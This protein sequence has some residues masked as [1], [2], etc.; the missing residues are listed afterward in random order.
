MQK[1]FPLLLHNYDQQS[2][3]RMFS[4]TD[5][6]ELVEGILV[7]RSMQL[8]FYVMLEQYFV[9]SVTFSQVEIIRHINIQP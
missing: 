7:K 4:F 3:R 9:G 1:L 8:F 2:F 5:S 6:I